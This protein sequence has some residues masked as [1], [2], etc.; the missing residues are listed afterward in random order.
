MMEE[1]KLKK[2]VFKKETIASLSNQEQARVYGASG[3]NCSIAGDDYCVCGKGR[4]S[5]DGSDAACNTESCCD[6][7]N[8]GGGTNPPESD[9][10]PT[11]GCSYDKAIT[12]VGPCIKTIKNCPIIV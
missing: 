5:G 8:S 3:D 7:C 12:C 6:K 10:C 11:I 1:T 2:L 4:G 9:G